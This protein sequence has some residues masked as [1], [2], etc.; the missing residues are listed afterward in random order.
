MKKSFEVLVITL[1]MVVFFT[2]CTKTF[3]HYEDKLYSEKTVLGDEDLNTKTTNVFTRQDA[4][5]KA[6]DIFD[7]GLNIKIDRTDFT[8]DVNLVK[9]DRS[10]SLQWHISWF[11]DDEKIFYTCVLDSSTGE[12]VEF[13]WFNDSNS[14]SNKVEVFKLS[15]LEIKNLMEPLLK[16]LDIDINEYSVLTDLD[17][18]YNKYLDGIYNNYIDITLLHNKNKAE[19]Y[20]ISIDLANKKVMSFRK[21]YNRLPK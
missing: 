7:K 18:T 14:D 8:E 9:N 19:G 4:I 15:D 12:I 20:Y 13:Q 1:L 10:R 5:K 16:E 11:K 3:N 6:L 17:L 21:L 2:G